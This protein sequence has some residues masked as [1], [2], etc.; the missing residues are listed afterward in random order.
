[1]L[2]GIF[3]AI[4]T[5]F[6]DDGAIDP[7]A[8]KQVIRFAIEGG[9]SGIVFP[10]VASEYN[11][12]SAEERGVLIQVL[13]QEVD[14]RIPLIA[15]I[16][17]KEPKEVI[18]LG[19]E[20]MTH[21]ISKLML[22]APSHLGYDVAKHISFFREIT[23]ALG[24]CEIILQNAPSPIGAGLEADMLIEIVSQNSSI[25]Y[26]K[27]ETLPSGPTISALLDQD[28]P[29]LIGVFG[30]GGARYIIDELNRG[31]LGAVPALEII[32]IH[33]ALYQAYTQGDKPH[34]RKLYQQSLPLLTAQKIYRMSLTKYVLAKRGIVDAQFIRAPHLTL[35]Q[36]A[37][38]DIDQM[39]EDLQNTNVLLQN[40]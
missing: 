15:G 31:A 13:I 38:D 36:Q 12:L 27:E 11:Y 35:D 40:T 3:P 37:K 7:E 19:Q 32:D 30:G 26:L 1:M 24:D 8:Q 29:H 10:G 33:A 28:I 18:A 6:T 16:S 4:P 20:A 22:M 17:A 5:C 25:T 21:G 9:A 14:G 39:L 34:A 2:T 23:D